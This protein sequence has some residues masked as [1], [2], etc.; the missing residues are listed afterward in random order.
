M[1]FA[2]AAWTTIPA[3][4]AQNFSILPAETGFCR[5]LTSPGSFPQRPAPRRLAQHRQPREPP[6][7]CAAKHGCAHTQRPRKERGSSTRV[8]SQ[9]RHRH[10]RPEAHVEFPP[11]DTAV[12]PTTRGGGTSAAMGRRRC[13]RCRQRGAG[14]LTLRRV[15]SARGL[16]SSGCKMRFLGSSHT[17][18]WDPGCSGHFAGFNVE[19]VRPEACQAAPPGGQLTPCTGAPCV[20][21]SNTIKRRSGGAA[22]PHAFSATTALNV[23]GRQRL[24]RSPPREEG[25]PRPLRPSACAFPSDTRVFCCCFTG[26]KATSAQGKKSAAAE[27]R[28][29]ACSYILETLLLVSPDAIVPGHVLPPGCHLLASWAGPGSR[30]QRPLELSA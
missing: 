14:S 25:P 18:P 24:G 15:F 5:P 2:G 10:T 9:K 21:G 11:G 1:T 28:G 19:G 29:P 3:I 22:A 6:S 20:Y 30:S 23:R 16:R 26:T 7:L 27:K 12:A 17:V 13:H 4:H 8:M